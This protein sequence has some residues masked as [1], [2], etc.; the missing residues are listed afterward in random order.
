M[1]EKK[2]KGRKV[3]IVGSRKFYDDI[4]RL[5]EELE[6]NKIKVATAGKW[7]KLKDDT[8]ETEKT[9][10]LKAFE[11]IDKSEVVYIIAFEGYVGKSGVMEMAYAYARNKKLISSEKIEELSAQ[12]LISKVMNS[13]ELIKY[14]K[15]AGLD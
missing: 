13:K 11:I 9:A 12:A 5:V 7:D 4:E 15:P 14:C 10:L 1:E 6:D 2:Q 8:L 3:F